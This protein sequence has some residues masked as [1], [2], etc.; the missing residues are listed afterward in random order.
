MLCL[1]KA[2][3]TAPSVKKRVCG[4]NATTSG[5]TSISIAPP[6]PPPIH[7]R[8]LRTNKR[9]FTSGFLLLILLFLLTKSTCAARLYCTLLVFRLFPLIRVWFEFL[10]SF[11]IIFYLIINWFHCRLHLLKIHYWDDFSLLANRFHHVPEH[12]L[13][14]TFLWSI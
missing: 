4:T 6:T 11:C 13:S 14:F 9:L 10:F 1:G 2:S 8:P 7:L 12:L 3:L 5:R